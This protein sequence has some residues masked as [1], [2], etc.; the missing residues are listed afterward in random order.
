MSNNSDITQLLS[1]DSRLKTAIPGFNVRPA[2]LAMA[3]AVTK[4]IADRQVLICEAGTGTGKTFAYLIPAI[5][6]RKKVMMLIYLNQF[7]YTF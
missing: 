7:V 6:S 4:A 5:L 1:G 3:Q 2:Q